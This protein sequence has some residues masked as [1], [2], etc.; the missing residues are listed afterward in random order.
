L[1]AVHAS[2]SMLMLHS[3]LVNRFLATSKICETVMV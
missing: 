3:F 1:A 2:S